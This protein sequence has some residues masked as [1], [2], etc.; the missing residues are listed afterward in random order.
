[1]HGRVESSYLGLIVPLSICGGE[2]FAALRD[3]IVVNTLVLWLANFDIFPCRLFEGAYQRLTILLG[4][5]GRGQQP[6]RH[7]TYVTPIQR[8]YT[9]ERSSLIERIAYTQTWYGYKKGVFPKLASVRQEDILQKMVIL[10][11]GNT[12]TTLASATKT[13]HVVYYQEAVNSWVKA[14]RHIPYYKK[15]GVVM[16]PPHGR[17]LYFDNDRTAHIVCALMNSTLFYLWFA[18]YSD[19]FHLSHT[20]VQS[21]PIHS[22]LCSN[23][24]LLRLAARL[25]EAIQSHAVY[26]TRNTRTGDS[27]AIEEYRV[28]CSK[29][30]LDEIDCV[31][32]KLYGFTDEE[33]DFI[34]HYDS[35]YRIGKTTV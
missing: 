9:S 17:L 23:E 3:T 16:K 19:G 5:Q 24:Q 30:M 35:K 31:L 14:T 20:L 18:T 13:E 7:K 10:T 2:R 1:M 32:A 27:I 12:V 29:S 21:F 8:W 34:I 6:D 4:K 11:S 33:L 26:S 25:E 28:V 15:N 22:A